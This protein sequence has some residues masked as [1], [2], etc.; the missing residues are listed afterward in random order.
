MYQRNISKTGN[1]ELNNTTAVIA[2]ADGIGSKSLAVGQFGCIIKAVRVTGGTTT[3]TTVKFYN[4]ANLIKTLTSS[5]G[6]I[7]NTDELRMEKNGINKITL[8]SAG[9]HSTNGLNWALDIEA[10]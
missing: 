1:E 6:A 4:G 9:D 10:K 7:S 8:T 3:D 2:V 5:S